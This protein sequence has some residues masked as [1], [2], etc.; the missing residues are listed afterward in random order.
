MHDKKQ[1]YLQ[2]GSVGSAVMAD[3]TPAYTPCCGWQA[4]LTTLQGKKG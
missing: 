3:N 1:K 2:G 4:K